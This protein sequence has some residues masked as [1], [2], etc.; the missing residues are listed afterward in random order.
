[1]HTHHQKISESEDKRHSDS[2]W[3]CQ[4]GTATG[5]KWSREVFFLPEMALRS[6]KTARGLKLGDRLEKVA[7][8]VAILALEMTEDVLR[9]ASMYL[10]RRASDRCASERALRCSRTADSAS[11]D[12]QALGERPRRP[13]RIEALAASTKRREKERAAW[14]ML[15][16]S[17][18]KEGRCSTIHDW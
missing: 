7:C 10:R 15:T 11:E 14:W 9:E 13:N 3:Q 5:K 12:H 17:T 2:D 1:M 18:S 6:L 16:A 4:E 8:Q